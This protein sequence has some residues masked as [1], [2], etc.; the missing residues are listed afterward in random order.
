VT[1]TGWLAERAPATLTTLPVQ[2]A[3]LF[4]STCPKNADPVVTRLAT[5]RIVGRV[6]PEGGQVDPLIRRCLR[7]VVVEPLQAKNVGIV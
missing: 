3:M 5:S 2:G 7:R 6:V 1:V 4:V